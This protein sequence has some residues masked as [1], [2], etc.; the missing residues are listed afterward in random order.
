MLQKSNSTPRCAEPPRSSTSYIENG[1]CIQKDSNRNKNES[2][3]ERVS[4]SVRVIRRARAVQRSKT[5]ATPTIDRKDGKIKSAGVSHSTPYALLDRRQV[6]RCGLSTRIMPATAAPMGIERLNTR[7]CGRGL[8]FVSANTIRCRRDNRHP[9]QPTSHRMKHQPR[10]T[11]SQH[12]DK[13]AP[14]IA[15][16]IRY[17]RLLFG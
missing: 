14:H 9:N 7:E 10:P 17:L 2:A 13:N 6:H 12:K 16:G 5:P 3:L 1:E 4:R 11:Q 15:G 8:Q